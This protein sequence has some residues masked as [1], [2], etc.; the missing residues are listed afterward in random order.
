[1]DDASRPA[2]EAQ[3]V[4]VDV[5]GVALD[6]SLG[7]PE[8]AFGVVLF[9]HGGESGS[10]RSRDD[11]VAEQLRR[12]GLATLQVDLAAA[13]DAPDEPQADGAR[14]DVELLARRAM[15]ACDWLISQSPTRELPIGLF[16]ASAGAAVALAAAAE[17]PDLVGAVV[18]RGG[19]PDLAGL[20]LPRVKA[21]TLL[22]VGGSD[23]PVISLNRD[24]L[25]YMSCERSLEVVPGATHLFE[26]AGALE[27]VA[28]LSGDWFRRYLAGD[29]S[30]ER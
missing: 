6:G 26:E 27:S 7:V 15:G 24:A 9:V 28:R 29:R 20:A 18:S 8:R 21:P 12:G 23:Y 1:M 25:Q 19:R 3:A 14:L 30:R 2:G 16:G 11:Y 17:R 4:R 5:G 22:I 13:D 10:R